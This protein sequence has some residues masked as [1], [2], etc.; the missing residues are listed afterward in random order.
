MTP[1]G[2]AVTA[3]TFDALGNRNYRFFFGG[4]TISVTGSWLQSTAQAW[5]ILELTHSP[6][7]L[8]LLL[9]V[10]FLPNSLLQPFG[11]VVGD[12]WPKRRVLIVTQSSFAITAA[13]LGIIEGLHMAKVWEVFVVVAVFGVISVVDGPTR[14]AFVPEMVG[15]RR[16]SNAVA[17]NSMVYNGARVIGPAIAGGL[18]AAVGTAACF[19]LNA[20][21]YLA[22]IG[23][24]LLMRPEELHP[25]PRFGGA[26]SEVLT[27]VREAIGYVRRS[28]EVALVIILMA[29]VSVFSYNLTIMI[30]ALARTDLH[31][32]AGGFGLLSASLGAG[33]L[34]GALGVAYMSRASVGTLL[35]G[36]G[37]F[38]LFL[39]LSGQVSRLTS[40]MALL[41]LAGGG[42]T[43]YSAM[44]NSVVL[45]F[46]P[47]RLQSRVMSLYLWVFL[48]STPLGSL[49]A[50]G[51][52]QAWG[53][54]V[55]MALGGAL[56]ILAAAGGTWWWTRSTWPKTAHP[57]LP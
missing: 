42:L 40:A 31:S 11:G 2:R 14:Q 52:E 29:I 16:M 8:G 13:V 15:K 19:D 17:L 45:T 10:Q 44:S 55:T 46:T 18:I 54:R 22:A 51:V 9:T 23:G 41:A 39:A 1:S 20:V 37:F 4:Q 7:V 26:V 6:L 24:L 57:A 3:R 53:D 50:G 35:I 34:V 56:A 12:R 38:G 33:A 27:E 25:N 36:C 30:T 21:S 48:G 49:F 47:G 5:L 32:G 28:R 43:V